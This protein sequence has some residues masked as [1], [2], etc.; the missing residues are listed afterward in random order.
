LDELA[1]RREPEPL[2]RGSTGDVLP[3]EEPDCGWGNWGM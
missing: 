3:V 2:L 1:K